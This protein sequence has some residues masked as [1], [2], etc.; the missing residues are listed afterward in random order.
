MPCPEC[1]LLEK[2]LAKAE[3]FFSIAY[4]SFEANQADSSAEEYLRL[5]Q[6]L[7]IAQ[8]RL[9][10]ARDIHDR[11]IQTHVGDKTDQASNGG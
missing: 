10:A 9:I 6:V 5:H 11:H 3:L 7:F 8:K 4:Q 1:K 2:E